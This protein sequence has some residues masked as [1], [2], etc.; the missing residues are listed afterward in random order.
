[1]SKWMVRGARKSDAQTVMFSVDARSA[2]EAQAKANESGVMVERVDALG[3]ATMLE[4]P[5]TVQE[6]P[7]PMAYARPVAGGAPKYLGLRIV[8]FAASVGAWLFYLMALLVV[9]HQVSQRSISQYYANGSSFDFLMTRVLEEILLPGGLL[10]GGGILLHAI[11][12]ACNA[13][14]DIARNT[15]PRS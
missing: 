1:M 14:R 10:I 11:A 13:L 8:A 12:G 4:M 15:W 2:I 6:P 9:V 7:T 3:G 5:P